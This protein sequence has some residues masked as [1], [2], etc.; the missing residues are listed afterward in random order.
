MTQTEDTP[1]SGEQ[2]RND[3]AASIHGEVEGELG[4][5]GMRDK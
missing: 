2:H 1:I 4:M 5:D 3:I